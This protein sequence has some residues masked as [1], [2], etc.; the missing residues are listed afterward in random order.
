MKTVLFAIFV[1]VFLFSS[2]VTAQSPLDGLDV[3]VSGSVSAIAVQADGKIIIGGFF[4]Q[5]NGVNRNNLARLNVNRTL[6]TS[7]VPNPNGSVYTILTQPNGSILVGGIFTE[8]GSVSRPAIARLL[9]DGTL[10]SDFY[11]GVGGWVKTIALESGGHVLIGGFFTIAGSPP[12]NHLARLDKDSGNLDGSFLPD[13]QRNGI[14]EV[15]AIS[16]QSN[17][18][19][20]IGGLFSSVGG[21]ARNCLARIDPITGTADSFDP[22][23]TSATEVNTIV[24]QPNGKILVGGLYLGGFVTKK[25][26]RIDTI[27][28]TEDPTFSATFAG[29]IETGYSVYALAVQPNGKVLVGGFFNN[30]N[31]EPSISLARLNSNGSIDPAFTVNNTNGVVN[32]FALQSSGKILV[33]GQFTT[34]TSGGWL[35]IRNNFAG[36]EINGNVD[37]T[38]DIGTLDGAI[39]IIVPQ[40]DGKVIIAGSFTSVLGVPRN[41]IARLNAD[42][43]L[44]MGFDPNPSGGGL[45]RIFAVAL[46]AFGR[47]YVGGEFTFIGGQSR[48]YIAR[49]DPVTGA[50][51]SFNPMPSDYVLAI[52][53]NPSGSVFIGGGFQS[54]GG[55]GFPHIAKLDANTGQPDPYFKP[56][57]NG[58]VH[59]IAQEPTGRVIFAGDFTELS[60]K[61]TPEVHN[62]IAKVFADGTV[63]SSFVAGIDARV[64]ALKLQSDGQILIGGNFTTVNAQV[65][66]YIARLSFDGI[67]DPTFDP[68]A[69]GQVNSISIQSNGKIIITGGFSTVG[70]LP[71]N[72]VARLDEATGVPEVL[73]GTVGQYDPDVNGV[74]YAS[75]ILPDGKILIGGDFI[76]VGG[77]PRS[78]FARLTND[79]YA[80]SELSI[81]RD[82]VSWQMNGSTPQFSGVRFLL[83]TDGGVTYALLGIGT[84]GLNSAKNGELSRTAPQASTYT[85]AGL[86]LPVGQEILIRATDPESTTEKVQGAFLL[87]PTAAMVS[88]TGTVRTSGGMGL[89]NAIVHMTDSAGII[90]TTRTSSFGHYR[91]D[92]IEAGQIV[93]IAVK[94]KSYQYQPQLVSVNGSLVD[95]DF[96]PIGANFK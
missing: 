92:D 2:M 57:P 80:V 44:D 33:G 61:G 69:N 31:G 35:S 64:L 94:S 52:H 38:L 49:L 9:P 86:D 78:N 93:V 58:D 8:V 77:V 55:D 59:A 15:R 10:D 73:G 16:V 13:V 46:G 70:G 11:A 36:L 34:I 84:T 56:V 81:T 17:G 72:R 88:V 40:P 18:K 27:T 63:I 32:S 23:S 1:T 54:I 25:V 66:N 91:F 21:L 60:P 45:G 39:R 47:V 20:I 42:G 14:V 71:R 67:V 96:V 19:I 79:T 43:S 28:G 82:S 3:N 6:D 68:N 48:Q 95:I 89:S 50:A 85:L 62:R 37:K 12:Q 65:R 53:V 75:A 22:Y 29:N 30:V 90:R 4:T 24:A 5:V 83:S 41:K 74:V 26:A 7:F 87:A 76:T 51:D